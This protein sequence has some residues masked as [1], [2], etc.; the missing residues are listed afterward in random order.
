MEIA[1]WIH[2]P[3]GLIHF[4]SSVIGLIIGLYLLI[5]KKGTSSHKLLGKI[6][7]FSLVVVNISALF[8]YDFNDGKIGPFHYL[9]PVSLFFLLYGWIPML[10]K[11]KTPKTIN[12]HIIGMIG[13]SLGLWAAG[14][15]EYYM[16]E[17][18][19]EG[20]DKNAQIL[21]SFLISLPFAILMTVLITVYINRQ[22]KQLNKTA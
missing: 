15:T 14:A 19:T 13:A 10:Q 18:V 5:V 4:I 2:S 1:N 21:Y 7:G 8:I 11:K 6:F 9:I 3:Q 12:K 22:K 17:I 20:M 16:R